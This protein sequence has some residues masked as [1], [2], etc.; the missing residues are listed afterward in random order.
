MFDIDI[1]EARMVA[2]V[3][4]RGDLTEADITALD[5]L[6]SESRRDGH[7]F[8]CIYDLTEVSRFDLAYDYIA[9]R[10]E[11]PQAYPGRER[12]YV[13]GRDE[14]RLLTRFFAGYQAAR[15]Q[16]EPVI[17]DTLDEAMQ[18]LGVNRSDFRPL[19]LEN[20]RGAAPA[21]RAGRAKGGRG[22]RQGDSKAG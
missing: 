21:R 12:I 14:L 9:L 16:R 22:D 8:D 11:V 4:F 7:A 10:G 13:V 15:K 2:L 20:S 17:V 18:R 5:K 19:P 3:R 6:A 1:C